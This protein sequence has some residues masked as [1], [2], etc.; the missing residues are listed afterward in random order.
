MPKIPPVS[1]NNDDSVSMI[2]NIVKQAQKST[3]KSNDLHP[4]D[5]DIGAVNITSAGDGR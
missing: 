4:R 3:K 5:G 1:A 2:V